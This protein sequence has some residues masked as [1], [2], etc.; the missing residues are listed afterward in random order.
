ML[1]IKPL[2]CSIICVLVLY[3]CVLL[4]ICYCVQL[5]REIASAY[6]YICV[7]VLYIC[8]PILYICYLCSC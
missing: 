8:V 6:Y 4:Y 5:L 3:I 2:L 1:C 7:L